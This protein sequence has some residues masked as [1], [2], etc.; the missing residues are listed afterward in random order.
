MKSGA[1]WA[2]RAVGATVAIGLVIGGANVAQAAPGSG[3]RSLVQSGVIS[4]Q[5]RDAYRDAVR[6][7]KD[8][9]LSCP[10]AKSAALDQLVASGELTQDQADQIAATKGPRGGSR[11]VGTQQQGASFQGS[12]IASA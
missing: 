9:G 7:L 10:E 1:R 5:E 6:A 4:V 2:I 3:L 12:P 8:E 11:T